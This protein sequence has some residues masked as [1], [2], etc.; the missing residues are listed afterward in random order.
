M[1]SMNS[2]ALSSPVETW[3]YPSLRPSPRP[4]LLSTPGSV[5]FSDE[6]GYDSGL[7]LEDSG[8]DNTIVYKTIYPKL[9]PLFD[10]LNMLQIYY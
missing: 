9:I 6:F 4:S 3:S 5:R 7:N 2:L 8:K 1:Q 10:W